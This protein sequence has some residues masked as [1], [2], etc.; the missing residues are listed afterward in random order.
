MRAGPRNDCR[1]SAELFYA[2]KT[3]QMIPNLR[4]SKLI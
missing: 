1:E 4:G 2:E 3:I